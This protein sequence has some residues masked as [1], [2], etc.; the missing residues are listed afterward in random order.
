ME[1]WVVEQGEAYEG[2][3]VVGV[4]SS[5]AAAVASIDNKWWTIDYDGDD[6]VTMSQGRFWATV[7]RFT[8]L[9]GAPNEGED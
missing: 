9:D 6:M 1:V 8:V 5:K 4:Y 2:G 7:H 3:E